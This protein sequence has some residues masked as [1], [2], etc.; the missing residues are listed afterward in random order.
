MQV[1]EL[2][3]FRI[4]PT[5][6]PVGAIDDTVSAEA[7]TA[8]ARELIKTGQQITEGGQHLVNMQLDALGQ[9]NQIRV[10]D[11]LNQLKETSLKLQFDPQAGFE[12]VRGIDALQRPSGK[13]LSD[14]YGETL[15]QRASGIEDSLSNDAQKIAFRAHANDLLTSFKGNAQQHEGKEFQTYSLSV[16]E[17]TIKNRQN[18]IVLN[19][20]NPDV[21]GQ[22][23]TSIKAAAFDQARLLG[24]SAEWAE[25]QARDSESSA[26]KLAA[27]TALEKNDATYADA[28]VK[29]F[30]GEMNADD[31]LSV[32][33]HLTK[34]LDSQTAVTAA[35][36]TIQEMG[37]RIQTSDSDRAF[38]IALGA[39]SGGK[40][41]GGAGSVAGPNEPTTSPK[42]AI[43]VAQVMPAT[44]PEAA[45]LA[46]LD[47]DEAK[48]KDD[49]KYNRALGK[50]YFTEQ[51][52]TNGGNLAMAYAAY[53]AGPG[54]LKEARDAAQTKGTPD[55]WLQEMP[56]ETQNYVNKNMTSFGAG[57]G[58]YAKP[59]LL[60]IQDSV[61]TKVGTGHP[62][63][64]RMALEEANRQYETILKANKQHEEEA[65]ATAMRGVME[66]GGRY[67]SLPPNVRGAVAPDDVGTVMDFAKKVSMGD[68]TTSPLL[69]Q[70]LSAD[71][72]ALRNMTDDQFFGLRA[73][74]SES[75][76]K[77]FA[78]QRA[79]LITGT[80]ENGPGN[81]NNEAITRT[82]NDRMNSMGIDPTPKDGSSDAERVGAVR[83]FVNQS[84][85]VEQANRGKKMSDVEASQFIDTLLSQNSQVFSHGWLG[86]QRISRTGDIPSA[87]RD[88]LTSAFKRKGI[89]SPSDTDLLNAY[90][91]QVRLIQKKNAKAKTNG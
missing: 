44:G 30:S 12:N 70:K 27:M 84:I 43:G 60:D 79:G 22:A 87:T 16:R 42:G 7:S 71:P 8:G 23:V 83:R 52:R 15:G 24:K 26:H 32:N 67:T 46:G 25:A 19:Y 5:V 77:H 51:L 65:K 90:W 80:S 49:P 13:S 88:A 57:G 2:N 76:F 66:N 72:A 31:I 89:D 53:N 9:A 48:F 38:N 36:S 11:S 35:S 55:A 41:F 6:Q 74:L 40:Q 81:M 3:N 75:D 28:Y 29:K 45:K 78:D 50:A 56:T 33:G 21:V 54:R 69:Y 39:E 47:W 73:E 34:E 4:T 59:S 17:G 14:E 86:S 82:L 63:R 37:A 91:Q 10:D 68:D 85:A 20:N 18:E 58:Q 62:E 61:R 64:L 1:P